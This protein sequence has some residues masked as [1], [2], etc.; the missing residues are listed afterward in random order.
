[1]AGRL[2][3]YAPVPLAMIDGDL[4]LEDQAC[5]GLRLWAAN[6]DH[7]TAIMPLTTALPS[8]S[9]VPLSARPGLER[10]SLEPV[11]MAYRP[12]R[13]LLHLPATRRRIAALIE[14]IG[15]SS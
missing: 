9:W 13:F 4:H 10:V 5:D 12:D 2:L 7:V 11:P 1:M 3:I 8:P 15:L 6:F 14:A